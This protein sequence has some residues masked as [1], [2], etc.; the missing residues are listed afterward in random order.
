LSPAQSQRLLS[1]DV[2]RGLTIAGMILVNCPGNDNVY[3]VLAHAEWDGWTLADL[4]FP[5]FLIIVGVSIAISLGRRLERGDKPFDVLGQ[6]FRR[7]AIIFGLGLLVSVFMV[8]TLGVFRVP[9]VL[10]RIALCNF[11][12]SF[13]FLKTKP[14]GQVFI[15]CALLAVYTALM[16]W[17]PVP[18]YGPGDLSPEGNIASFFDRL[19]FGD[20]MWAETHDPEGLLSTIPAVAT[21]IMGVWAGGWL[22]GRSKPERKTIVLFVAGAL[23]AAGGVLLS[24][25]IPI[26]K[27]IWSSSFTLFTGG[28]AFCALAVVHVVVDSLGIEAWGRPFEVFGRNALASYFLS[29]LFYGVQEFIH[30]P[31]RHENVKEWLCAALFGSLSEPN[32][33]LAYAVCYL[34][35]FLGVMWIFYRKRI[36]IKV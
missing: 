21:T 19:V 12:A 20:H 14:R 13:I 22:I 3:P 9:G 34:G 23:C 33:A 2:F 31:G 6:A 8:S 30:L 35:F 4:I 11:A 15:V 17:T 7:S 18:G 29:E 28:V 36:F 32:A 24:R 5:A 1:L 26:N 27:N 10:Q 25:W 16:L